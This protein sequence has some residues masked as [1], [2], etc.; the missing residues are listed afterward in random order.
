M[1]GLPSFVIPGTRLFLRGG[2]VGMTLCTEIKKGR[3]KDN[4]YFKCKKRVP[5]KTWFLQRH[6]F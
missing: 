2:G 1:D 4:K 3:V 5:Q 6:I